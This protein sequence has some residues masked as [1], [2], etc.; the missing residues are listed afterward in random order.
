MKLTKHEKY[1]MYYLEW[2]DGVKSV[3]FY[4]FTRG[5]DHVAKISSSM[6][7]QSSLEGRT[8]V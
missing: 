5:K 3:D 1:G 4:S 2:P 8:E 7:R 6:A